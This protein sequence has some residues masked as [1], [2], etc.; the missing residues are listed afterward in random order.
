MKMVLPDV[1]GHENQSQHYQRHRCLH[2]CLDLSARI[3]T[4]DRFSYH[5]CRFYCVHRKVT[6]FPSYRPTSGS[7]TSQPAGDGQILNEI[8]LMTFL[9]IPPKI[10]SVT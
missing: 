8:L 7:R 10:S 4:P 2:V 3:T 1:I 5:T 6:H 9:D